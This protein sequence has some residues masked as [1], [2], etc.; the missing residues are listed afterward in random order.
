M[1]NHHIKLGIGED[2]REGE[3]KEGVGVLF[4]NFKTHLLLHFYST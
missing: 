4:F 1:K 3:E 2:G